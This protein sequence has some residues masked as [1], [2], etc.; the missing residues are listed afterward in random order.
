VA[1]SAS[2]DRRAATLWRTFRECLRL[3]EWAPV[4]RTA[5]IQRAGEGAP[6]PS[7]TFDLTVP[8]PGCAS[9]RAHRALTALSAT[10]AR[11]FP[12]DL[13]RRA[14]LR[15]AANVDSP[16]R[17]ARGRA[18]SQSDGQEISY[19]ISKGDGRPVSCSYMATRAQRGPGVH[20]WTAL[21]AT[22][23]GAWRSTCLDTVTL[24]LPGHGHSARATDHARYSLPGYAAVLTAFAES[25]DPADAV[26][27]GWSLGGHIALE[28]A[29]AMPAAAGFVI[30]GTPP[31]A[32]A[33][34]LARRYCRYLP[35]VPASPT[36]SARAAPRWCWRHSPEIRPGGM[37]S[38]SPGRSTRD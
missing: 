12:P 19:T 17:A 5:Y 15:A 11:S 9:R 2:A 24:D 14:N 6:A 18:D 30:F 13:P 7:D 10:A 28:A 31:V 33:D 3:R 20:C 36:S 22:V 34:Q 16:G 8:G 26:V 27:I 23:S 29:P 37:T 25:L 21:S 32:S 35:W 1:P 4:L 38:C